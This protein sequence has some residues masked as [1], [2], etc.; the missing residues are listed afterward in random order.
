LNDLPKVVEQKAKKVVEQKA[1]MTVAKGQ[2]GR[3]NS[4]YSYVDKG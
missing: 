2:R 4:C 3:M 1:K